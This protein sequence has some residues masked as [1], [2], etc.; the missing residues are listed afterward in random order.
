MGAGFALGVW[1]VRFAGTRQRD[2]AQGQAAAREPGGCRSWR[3]WTVE[4]RIQHERVDQFE[5]T[6]TWTR[7]GSCRGGQLHSCANAGQLESAGWPVRERLLARVRVRRQCG[8]LAP[9]ECWQHELHAEP[10]GEQGEHERR[11]QRGTGLA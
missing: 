1:L 7:T 10:G 2:D 3:I 9:A 4:E 8:P 5:R 6:R 11:E